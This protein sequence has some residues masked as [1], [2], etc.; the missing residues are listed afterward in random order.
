[1]D[2]GPA[3]KFDM[4]HKLQRAGECVSDLAE[5]KQKKNID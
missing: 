2:N 3:R 4:A 1:M 5:V